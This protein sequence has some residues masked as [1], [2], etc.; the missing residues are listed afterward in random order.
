MQILECLFIAY[1][2]GVWLRDINRVLTGQG[3]VREK[4]YNSRSGKSQGILKLV[5][6]FRL[7]CPDQGK[8][9]EFIRILC[10]KKKISPFLSQG[11]E[12]SGA[13]M[14]ATNEELMCVKRKYGNS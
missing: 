6:E 5:R 7:I 12:I 13:K 11:E 3:Q 9:R 4:T 2:H 10:K 1:N 8:V 14:E